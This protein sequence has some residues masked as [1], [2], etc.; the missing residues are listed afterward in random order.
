LILLLLLLKVVLQLM[1]LHPPRLLLTTFMNDIASVLISSIFMR[2]S[3]LHCHFCPLDTKFFL[4]ILFTITSSSLF[5]YF[6]PS[7]FLLLLTSNL[8]F[9]IDLIFCSHTSFP[10][11]RQLALSSCLY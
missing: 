1:T 3:I 8:K 11:T 4:Y 10:Q 7:T 9:K 5:S 2:S 6:F